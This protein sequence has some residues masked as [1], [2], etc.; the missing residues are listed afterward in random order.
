MITM[1][2]TGSSSAYK[3]IKTAQIEWNIKNR[4]EE[5]KN[6]AWDHFT[7]IVQNQAQPYN[8]RTTGPASPRSADFQWLKILVYQSLVS[9]SQLDNTRSSI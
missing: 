1:V 2:Y 5:K 6:Q 3:D 4:K 8:L 9:S 7:G